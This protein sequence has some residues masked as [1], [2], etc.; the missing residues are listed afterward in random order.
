M[1]QPKRQQESNTGQKR[2]CPKGVHACQDQPM[3]LS[4][5]SP[6]DPCSRT[7]TISPMQRRPRKCSG[8]R[9]R[10][11][12]PHFHA[13]TMAPM[14]GH[15]GAG[16]CAEDI[17]SMK[18]HHT[19]RYGDDSCRIRTLACHGNRCSIAAVIASMQRYHACPLWRSLNYCDACAPYRSLLCCSKHSKVWRTLL[20]SK[21]RLRGMATAPMPCPRPSQLRSTVNL[22]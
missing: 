11:V 2:C 16:S 14:P 17:T 3:V 5:A 8:D 19:A 18:R 22:V 6:A 1:P 4:R 9:L 10:V 12:V 7:A 15:G 13:M 20:Y 21:R